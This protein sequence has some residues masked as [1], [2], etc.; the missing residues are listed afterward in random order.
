M[1]RRYARRAGIDRDVNPHMLRHT[2][3]TELLRE[4]FNVQ[5]VQQLLRHSDI[6]T[7]VIY[8]HIFEAD[9]ARKP[10]S[11]ATPNSR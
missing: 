10:S 1:M 2:Y 5:E 3:A 9:L 6:R 11:A 4:G 7:T 8:T